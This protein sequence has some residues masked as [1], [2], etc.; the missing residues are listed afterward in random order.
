MQN[1][2]RSGRIIGRIFTLGK[3]NIAVT[4]GVLFVAPAA[5]FVPNLRPSFRYL[6]Q[7]CTCGLKSY[8]MTIRGSGTRPHTQT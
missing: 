8:P 6:W 4:M 7:L 2:A 3:S 5:A 1:H